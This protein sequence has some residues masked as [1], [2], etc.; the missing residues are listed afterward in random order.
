[1]STPAWGEHQPWPAVHPLR[2]HPPVNDCPLDLGL[3]FTNGLQFQ[4]NTT[5]HRESLV[6]LQIHIYTTTNMKLDKTSGWLKPCLDTVFFDVK[7]CHRF[8]RAIF[9]LQHL[10]LLA[11]QT[12]QE[13]LHGPWRLVL[14]WQDSAQTNFVWF[15]YIYKLYTYIYIYIYRSSYG[16]LW[17]LDSTNLFKVAVFVTTHWRISWIEC[18]IPGPYWCLVKKARESGTTLW[19]K[20]TCIKLLTCWLFIFFRANHISQHQALDG[21]LLQTPR[22]P[23]TLASGVSTRRDG[24]QWRPQQVTIRPSLF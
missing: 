6:L 19:V 20:K 17:P 9:P 16:H 2:W 18:C 14:H 1:M 13:V 22:E 4:L 8:H 5:C 11:C 3:K 15:V 12:L 21:H 7:E 24:L 23:V 10:T